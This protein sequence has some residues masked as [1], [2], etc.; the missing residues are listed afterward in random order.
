MGLDPDPPTPLLQKERAVAIE[1]AVTV[2]THKMHY[3]TS[4]ATTTYWMT[5]MSYQAMALIQTLVSL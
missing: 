2:Q 5:C 1:S 4:L 3:T